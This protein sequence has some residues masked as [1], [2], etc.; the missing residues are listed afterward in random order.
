MNNI[1]SRDI[2]LNIKYVSGQSR[3]EFEARYINQPNVT[4]D[5][6]EGDEKVPLVC[7]WD[8]DQKVLNWRNVSYRVDWFVDGVLL[9]DERDYVCK[10]RGNPTMA[11]QNDL[12]CP[13][14][15]KLEAELPGDKYQLGNHVRIRYEKIIYILVASL[16]Y[17]SIDSYFSNQFRNSYTSAHYPV[18]LINSYSNETALNIS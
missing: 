13:G 7:Q 9:P 10:P 8:V 2:N 14:T 3:V 16:W 4:F 15:N 12:P 5:D 18:R 11:Q 17:N 1:T 6:S